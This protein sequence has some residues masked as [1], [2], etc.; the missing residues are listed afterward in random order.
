MDKNMVNLIVWSAYVGLLDDPFLPHPAWFTFFS[1]EV[2]WSRLV[3]VMHF[4][5]ASQP[6]WP[7]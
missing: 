7:T 2:E 4:S 3:E 5:V 6:R 1:R